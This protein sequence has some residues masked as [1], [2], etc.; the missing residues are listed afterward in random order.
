M[1]TSANSI[2]PQTEIE[3]VNVMLS[4]IGESGVTALADPLPAQVDMARAILREQTRQLQNRFW[5]WNTEF[6]Y[7]VVPT[8]T[9]Y[10]W[11]NTDGSTKL[12]NI[13]KPPTIVTGIA[14]LQPVQM[15]RFDV[16]QAFSP[17]GQSTTSSGQQNITLD[18]ML[19]LSAKYQ[20]AA[21]SVLVFYDRANNCDGPLATN[22]PF[23]YLNIAWAFGYEYIP[24]SARD[25]V[26]IRSA[27]ILAKRAVG[28]TE[29]STL[30][31]DDEA[32]AWV[33]LVEDQLEED[34]YNIFDDGGIQA[35]RGIRPGPVVGVND[36][37]G[38]IR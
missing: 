10:V 28:S 26:A 5:R 22:F 11:T 21:Q 3:A 17:P 23:I 6:G 2:S 9:N 31:K 20:E 15:G 36:P 13:F 4:V 1:S 8:V 30:T 35:F 33:L 32:N 18:V 25:Y 24:Q 29:L 16:L 7:Q 37:R 12:L 19:R 14:G 34:D 38:T 27:R